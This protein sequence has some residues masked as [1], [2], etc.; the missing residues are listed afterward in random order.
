M[1]KGFRPLESNML[2]DTAPLLFP[3]LLLLLVGWLLP[4]KIESYSQKF[5]QPV[6][7]AIVN[8]YRFGPLVVVGVMILNRIK[9][10]VQRDTTY[11][12]VAQKLGPGNFEFSDL[13]LLVTG[14]GSS[15]LIL[16]GLISFALLSHKLPSIKSSSIEI[17]RSQ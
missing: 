16:L 2:G 3:I 12:E 1:L 7:K 14:D 17:K 10:I 9:T 5:S 13:S 6:S 11:L 8:T 15:E 4:S